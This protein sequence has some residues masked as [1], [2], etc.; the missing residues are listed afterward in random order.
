MNRRL[1]MRHC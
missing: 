1:P